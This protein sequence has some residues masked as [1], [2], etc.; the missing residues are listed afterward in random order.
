MKIILGRLI[1][2][3]VLLKQYPYLYIHGVPDL[4][5]TSMLSIKIPIDFSL[6]VTFLKLHVLLGGCQGK[7]L[8][9]PMK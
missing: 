7:S 3:E 8:L 2:Q 4:N 9:V 6:N 5:K 1:Y